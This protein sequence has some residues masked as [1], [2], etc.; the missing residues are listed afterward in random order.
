M[1]RICA[2]TRYSCRLCQRHSPRGSLGDVHVDRSHRP[3]L[4]RLWLGNSAARDGILIDLSLSTPRWPTLSQVQ[5]ADPGDLAFSVARFS[6]HVWRRPDQIARR[7][8]LARS[9]LSLLSL[10]NAADP[11]PGQSIPAF[12]PALVPQI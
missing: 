5:A 1:D 11:K 4:V 6:H 9:H 7:P 3:D 12:C 2:V 8:L 10:R